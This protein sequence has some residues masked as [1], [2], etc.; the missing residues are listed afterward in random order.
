MCC[1]E[2]TLCGTVPVESRVPQE[3]GLAK[4]GGTR[5]YL[6]V[7]RGGWR[8]IKS[9]VQSQVCSCVGQC[10]SVSTRNAKR[11]GVSMQIVRSS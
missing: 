7:G 3:K 10:S 2:T 1:G 8:T 4:V 11:V 5:S 9:R 6:L